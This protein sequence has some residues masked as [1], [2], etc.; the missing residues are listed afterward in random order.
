MPLQNSNRREAIAMSGVCQAVKVGDTCLFWKKAGCSYNGGTC[1][2]VV[3]ACTGCE[4]TKEYPSGQYCI[5][6]CEPEMKW[7][8]G[9]CNLATHVK[10]TNGN[11]GEKKLNPLKA[12]KRKAAGK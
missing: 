7:K 10:R 1:Y 6:F 12:S 11:G 8:V 9:A 3:D 2:P 4:R 5:S